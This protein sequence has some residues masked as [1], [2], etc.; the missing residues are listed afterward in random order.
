MKTL[1]AIFVSYQSK[2]LIFFAALFISWSAQSQ[3]LYTY[4]NT[5]P[6]TCY[7]YAYLDS[8]LV[9]IDEP[10][11]WTFE[12][13]VIYSDVSYISF[14]CSG[15]YVVTFFDLEGNS[16]TVTFT[17]GS[18]SSDPC[19]G[20]YVELIGTDP[21]PNTCDGAIEAN[22][23]GGTGP[24]TYAWSNNTVGNEATDLCQG[25]YSCTVTDA[26]GC[27]T[28]NST[29]LNG[30]VL[31]SDSITII[32][33]NTFPDS[34]VTQILDTVTIL[35]C[36]LDYSAVSSAGITDV[37]NDAA[38]V[39]VTWTLY[40]ALGQVITSYD[41]YYYNLPTQNA[42]YQGTLIIY[43]DGR[44][45]V[46]WIVQITDQFE[47]FGASA[48]ILTVDAFDISVVNPMG[49]ALNIFFSESLEGNIQLVD[50]NGRVVLSAP[51]VS[52]QMNLNTSALEAGLYVLQ[53]TSNKGAQVLKVL[54]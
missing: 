11:V 26:E 33:N 45:M 20:F 54:K 37:I 13:Q 51:I 18:G 29:I 53:I 32:I 43:C 7:G 24:Y 12:G 6:G 1:H 28:F 22:I 31:D 34:S 49:D 4:D 16:F 9:D 19:S 17:I 35:D 27:S 25:Y 5:E 42:V 14:L 2:A 47:Y 39:L 36:D 8:A 21:T 23:F 52:E 10:I 40:D 50:M 41:I 30:D 46:D 44:S 48:G 38:G 3:F 15:E